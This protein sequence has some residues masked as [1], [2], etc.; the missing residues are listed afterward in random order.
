MQQEEK[1]I[2]KEQSEN[3]KECMVIKYGITLV[4]IK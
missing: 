2:I 4:K 1:A 3:N